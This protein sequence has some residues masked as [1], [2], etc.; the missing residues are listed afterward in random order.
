MYNSMIAR[1]TSK[2]AT[3]RRHWLLNFETWLLYPVSRVSLHQLWQANFFSVTLAGVSKWNKSRELAQIGT[4]VAGSALALAERWLRSVWLGSRGRSS[5][6]RAMIE[7]SLSRVPRRLSP[8]ASW[9]VWGSVPTFGDCLANVFK[10][11]MIVPCARGLHHS[12]RAGLGNFLIHF[13]SC[14]PPGAAP[15][16]IKESEGEEKSSAHIVSHHFHQTRYRRNWKKRFPP[17]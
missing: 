15:T 14:F 16:S 7:L 10:Q 13:R 9:S 6:S 3:A 11:K 1:L 12:L 8:A 17:L 2:G 5:F 4:R